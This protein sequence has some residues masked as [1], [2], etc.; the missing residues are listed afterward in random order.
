MVPRAEKRE[1][2]KRDGEA[3]TIADPRTI[4]FKAFLREVDIR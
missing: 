4:F 1:A 3:P 2:A